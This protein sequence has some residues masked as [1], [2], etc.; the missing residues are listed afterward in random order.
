M[1]EKLVPMLFVFLLSSGLVSYRDSVGAEEFFKEK[2]IRFVVGFSPGGGFDV[3]SRTIAR[4][5][6][7]HVPGNPTTIV[8]NMPGAGSLVAA[9]F[10]YNRAT[11]DG[12]TIGNFIGPLVLQQVLGNKAANFDGRK[13]S[14]LG[15]PAPDHAVCI[16]TEASGITSIEKWFTASKPIKLGS[17]G[18]GSN[19]TDIPNILKEAIRLPTQIIQGYKGT[20]E[21]LLAMESGEVEGSCWSWL[22]MKTMMPNQLKSGKVRVVLQVT[23]SSHP[24]LRSVPLAMDYAKSDT[25][26]ALIRV[27][28]LV[29]SSALRPYTLPPGTSKERLSILREAFMKTM[30]E[31]DFLVDAK[32]AQLEIDPIDGTETEKMFSDLYKMSTSSVGKLQAVLLPKGGK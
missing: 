13:F 28:A 5:F 9:N 26:K 12:L 27:G 2:T 32:K 21:I 14:W 24:E 8:E 3:Y 23:L 20:S 19:T 25:D 30:V 15:V 18:P 17:V 29:Y 4:H 6:S 31:P 11:P 16:F 1:V 7:R 22:G 10:V